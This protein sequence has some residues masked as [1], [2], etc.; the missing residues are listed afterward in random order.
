MLR[1]SL[2]HDFFRKLLRLE[3]AFELNRGQVL[4]L[5]DMRDPQSRPGFEVFPIDHKLVGYL[6]DL[7]ATTN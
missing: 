2:Q 4:N 7:F 6:L 3:R 1:A 5:I